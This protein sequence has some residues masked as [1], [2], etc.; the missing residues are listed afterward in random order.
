MDNKTDLRI[1]ARLREDSRMSL[2][3]ISRETGIPVSTIFEKVK[4]KAGDIVKRNTCL[5]DFS[6]I[7]MNTRANVTLR[8]VPEHRHELR[9]FLEKNRNVNSLFKINNGYDYMV[10]VVFS[11]MKELEDFLEIL[12]GR[13]KIKSKH[14]FYVIEEIAQERF[15]NNTL[16]FDI[17]RTAC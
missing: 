15:L 6:K 10:D 12:E 11:N 13:F 16:L 7:G 9:T 8:T 5:L 4:K 1:V 3:K 14:V 2:T 17:D